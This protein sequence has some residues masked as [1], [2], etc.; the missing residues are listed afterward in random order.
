VNNFY[1]IVSGR[2]KLKFGKFKGKFL[3]EVP[4]WYLRFMVDLWDEDCDDESM[5][6]FIEIMKDNIN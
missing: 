2:V 1:E 6:D 5:W 3:S 4:L